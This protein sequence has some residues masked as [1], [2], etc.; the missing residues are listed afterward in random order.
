MDRQICTE[1]LD[2]TLP[3]L[4]P[5]GFFA[6]GFIK[7]KVP[8]LHDLRQRIYEAAQAL[9]PNMFRDVSELLWNVGNNVLRWKG[10]G[11]SWAVLNMLHNSD[12]HNISN[13]L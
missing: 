11:G 10:G 4:T 7:S 1:T 3:H 2:A 6:W 5:L 9:T 12:P 13:V 8:D